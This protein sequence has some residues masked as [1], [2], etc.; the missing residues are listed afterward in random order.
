VFW[1]NR[2]RA[3]VESF[4]SLSTRSTVRFA[5]FALL[6]GLLGMLGMQFLA[7]YNLPQF[8]ATML[9]PPDGLFA[10]LRALALFAPL[11]EELT[12]F[13]LALLLVS[14]I[15]GRPLQVIVPRVFAGWAVGAGFGWSEHHLAQYIDEGF[16]GLVARMGFHG[17]AAGLSMATFTLFQDARRPGLRWYSTC[18]SSTCHWFVN[19]FA[20]PVGLV[21]AAVGE[22]WLA[23]GW[24]LLACL[25]ALVATVTM[26]WL[27]PRLLARLERAVP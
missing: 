25:A 22:P 23:E 24:M 18:G 7:P 1:A 5:G 13:G 20:I 15:P 9:T 12:K 2:P 16:W 10:F 14:W 4:E 19:A 11:F 6:A 17:L 26:P 21:A 3:T 8:L 27:G